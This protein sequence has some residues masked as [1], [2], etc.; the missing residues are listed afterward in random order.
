VTGL[1]TLLRKELLESWRTLRLP[2][3]VVVF[4]LIGF[5]SPLLARFTPELI[6]ALGGSGLQI[7]LPP[8]TTADSVDQL[9]K[10]LGQFGILVAILLAM[11]SVASEKERGTAALLLTSPASRSAF[12]VAK[13]VALALV[14]GVATVAGAA[15]AWFYTA[16]LFEP[17]AVGPFAV[18]T[19]LLWLQLVV[20]MALTFL[21]STLT[22]SALAA[23]GLGFALLIVVGI[24]GALPT[25]GKLLPSALA[26]TARA[27][28]LGTGE[29][30]WT[31]VVSA[32]VLVAAVTALSLASFSRQE[33]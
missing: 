4:L 26:S 8:P 22:R 9:E 5:G 28:A 17:L 19:V 10:N 25:I 24:L 13:L 3:V 31:P 16:V 12:L 14:L 15:A 23:A 1:G 29:V 20:F 27:V 33:L 11:G 6:K 32:V 7:Q 30:S 21:G 18:A 2:L